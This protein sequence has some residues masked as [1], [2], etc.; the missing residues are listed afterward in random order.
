MQNKIVCTIITADYGHYALNLYDSLR[1]FDPDITF[2]IFISKGEFKEDILKKIN[3]NDNIFIIDYNSI[4]YNELLE[5]LKDK[6]LEEFHDAFRWGMK[7]VLIN[8]LLK[9]YQKVIYVDSD[10]YFYNSYNFLFDELEK[11]NVLLTPHWRSSVPTIEYSN[12]VHNFRDGLYN[13]GFVAAA[14]GAQDAMS[15][16]AK[17]VLF[18]CEV[19]RREGFYVDQRYLDLLPILFDK[20]KVLKH[21]GCNVANW[22]KIECKRTVDENNEVLI[23]NKYPIVFIHFTNTML[24]GIYYENDVLLEPFLLKYRDGLLNY[25]EK[26]IIKH[27]FEVGKFQK[28]RSEEDFRLKKN[29]FDKNNTSLANKIFKKLKRITK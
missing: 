9:K 2:A 25:S 13:A 1:Q 29:T 4:D 21:R 10:I 17:M 20:V 8:H 28:S 22:N 16:W 7:P 5:K 15:W 26:D 6:Y 23:N 12:F 27:Y 11:N 3:A 24:T 19:N 18:K 14:Q